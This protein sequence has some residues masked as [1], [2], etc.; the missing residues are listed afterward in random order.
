MPFDE[1]SRLTKPLTIFFISFLFL[2]ACQATLSHFKPPL[3]EEGEVFL[4]I[5]PFPQEAE[6]LRFKFETISALHSDGR[7]FALAVSLRELRSRD[8]RRQRLLAS[9]QLPPGS[10]LGLS[11]RVKDAVLGREEGEA[12]LLVPETAVRIDF[13]FN[14]T[15]KKSQ[16][17]SLEFKYLES[18]RDR[19]RFIPAFSIGI[20]APPITSLVGYV[21]NSGSNNITVF[22]KKSGQAV[23]VMATGRNPAGMALDQKLRRAYVA[24]PA[25]DMIEFID[26]TAGDI[27][28]RLRLRTGDRPQELA[29]TPD[30]KILLAA[31]TGPNTISFID[32]ISHLEVSRIEVGIGPNSILIDGTGRRGFVFNTLS[33]TISV[34]DIPNRTLV[35]TISTDPAP[36]RGQFN[37]RGDRL[38]VIHELSSYLT[39]I[40][41]NSL[42]IL[43]RFSV[44]MGMTSI[45]V[46]TLTDLVYLGRKNDTVVK[47]YDPFS[48]VPVDSINTG[49]G[50]IYMTI[51]GDENNLYMVNPE[52]KTL[53]R[54]N[55]VGKKTVAVIDVGESPYWVTLMGER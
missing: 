37:R 43:G 38:Y 33:N 44:R 19:I 2:S 27:T 20:P 32:S 6:R 47:V 45:K 14:V 25:E 29:L 12:A 31:N 55:L 26:V 46:D 52:M 50:I 9:G 28:D 21:T 1:E 7:E 15:R 34:I 30:G 10:Y 22:D 35:T 41:P 24:L 36:L 53:M 23:A 5:Q 54:T 13:P 11:F 8:T 49:A 40:D 17:I 42:S 3:E 18:I 51:D 39:V 48:F 16:L 4:Y